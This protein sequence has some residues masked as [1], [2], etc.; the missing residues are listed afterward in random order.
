MNRG[1]TIT[2]LVGV[3]L[4]QS[5]RTQAQSEAAERQAAEDAYRAADSLLSSTYEDL[6]EILDDSEKS[7]L[8]AEQ[9]RWIKKRDQDAEKAAEPQKGSNDENRT[10]HEKLCELT[11]ERYATLLKK[12]YQL[13]ARVAEKRR[14]AQPGD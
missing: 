13:Y 7:A 1:L 14:D 4:A 11:V 10:R 2:L 8:K 5:S 12:Y 6:I 3:V 9:S